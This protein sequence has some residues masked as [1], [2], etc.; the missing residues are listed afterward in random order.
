M[1][2]EQPGTTTPTIP[3]AQ[4]VTW[5][6]CLLGG[7]VYAIRRGHWQPAIIVQRGR[8][9]CRVKFEDTDNC[10]FRQYS[11]L[12]GRNPKKQGAD[13]P[14]EPVVEEKGGAGDMPLHI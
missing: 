9:G 3:L 2:M 8:V 11:E 13:K 1:T 5:H 10:A 14:T 4:R 12:V 7:T 6:T